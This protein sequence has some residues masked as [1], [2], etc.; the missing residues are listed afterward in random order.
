MKR[1]W[2]QVVCAFFL[3]AGCS[4]L[5]RTAP[6]Q[7]ASP[8]PPTWTAVPSPTATSPAA[9]TPAGG[10]TAA[11]TAKPAAA[12]S[13]APVSLPPGQDYVIYSVKSVKQSMSAAQAD[14]QK[15]ALHQYL[16]EKTEIYACDPDGQN[17]RLLFSDENL[18][19]F[20]LN[21]PGGGETATH[22]IIAA[23]T[24]T[25]KLYARMLPRDQFTSYEMPGSLYQL[26]TDGKN[27]YNKLFDFEQPVQFSLSPDAT[28]VAYIADN[29]LI[30]RSLYSGSE[31]NRIDLSAYIDNYIFSIGWAPGSQEIL[32]NIGIGDVHVAP[33]SAY[34]VA[35][36]YLADL[37]DNSFG[38]LN[39]SPFHDPLDL[40]FGYK[41]DPFSYSFYPSSSLLIGMARKYTQDSSSPFV[42]LY[43]T[44]AEGD[45]LNE[46][47]I[48]NNENVWIVKVS[49]G[50]RYIAYQGDRNITVTD[51]QQDFVAI[52]SG[53]APQAGADQQQTLIGWLG[54][55]TNES[56]LG[57]SPISL[58][59][60][61]GGVQIDALPPRLRPGDKAAVSLHPPFANTLRQSPGKEA[62][63]LGEI[64]AGQEVDV[65]EGPVYNGGSFWY[66]VKDTRT[67]LTGWTAEADDQDYWL[68]PGD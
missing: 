38:E 45:S 48:K 67:G 65:L 61:D 31:T 13:P 37:T 47:P 27:Q 64:L 21:S 22:G 4:A 32:L 15:L 3:F 46:I 8:I 43:S 60:L 42:R 9:S 34:H 23:S 39:A 2:L 7:A 29:Y 24:V 19:A 11:P 12:A 6:P 51:L 56:P 35:G 16:T 66:K 44:S 50:E 25:G 30:V 58:A 52:G 41:T 14:Q 17:T 33:Q 40:T 62:E 10:P 18:W 1:S 57:M 20:I 49:P 55:G 53:P 59:H 63:P 28:K 36:V 68:V 26:S 54:D 5:P